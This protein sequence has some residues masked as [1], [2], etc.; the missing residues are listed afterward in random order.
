MNA[1][2]AR[3]LCA[4]QAAR[5]IDRAYTDGDWQQALIDLHSLLRSSEWA[6]LEAEI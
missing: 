5:A 3:R 2:E 4:A 6:D 1:A